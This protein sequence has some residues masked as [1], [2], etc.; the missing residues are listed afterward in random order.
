MR[1]IKVRE[2]AYKKVTV[3]PLSVASLLTLSLSLSFSQKSF[4]SQAESAAF[5]TLFLPIPLTRRG[6]Q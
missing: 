1:R 5:F 4:A 6:Q 2:V 3:P